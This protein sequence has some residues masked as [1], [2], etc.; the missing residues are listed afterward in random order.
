MVYGY[1]SQLGG[2]VRVDSVV[3]EG[4]VVRLYLPRA[5]DGEAAA[6]ADD[7]AEE[8]ASSGETVLLVE[9]E[10]LVRGHVAVVLRQFGYRVVLAADGHE[11]LRILRG[12]ERV[13]LLFTDVV[14]PGGL[15]GRQLAR[16]AVR[17]RPGLPVLLTS[18]YAADV[19]ANQAPEPDAVA[20]LEKPYRQGELGAR[21]RQ[22]LG[23]RPVAR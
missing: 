18:G 22:A 15:D 11:A 12:G 19:G 23:Q 1:V 14:M 2:H 3:G 9:D 17:L 21:L 7:L 6:P 8:V 4:T 16:E 13:D 5:D 20:F 10:P